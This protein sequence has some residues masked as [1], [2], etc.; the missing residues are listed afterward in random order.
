MAEGGSPNAPVENPQAQ[1]PTQPQ[2]TPALANRGQP[3]GGKTP[4]GPAVMLNFPAAPAVQSLSL[5]HI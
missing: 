2:P 1:I 5:I 4:T 3:A